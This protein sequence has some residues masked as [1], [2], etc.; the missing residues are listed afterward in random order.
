MV[1]SSA[2]LNEVASRRHLAVI[3]TWILLAF[4]TALVACPP[5]EQATP[6]RKP[7][8]ILIVLDT[9]RADHL[10]SYGYSWD[11]SP[12]LDALARDGVVF[13]RTISPSPWTIP[14]IGSIL[15]STY[16]SEHHAGERPS[17]AV[18]DVKNN[19]NWSALGKMDPTL[20][21]IASL[22][23]EHGWT[24][25]AILA[26]P[27]IRG[28]GLFP[29]TYDQVDD[30]PGDDF[31]GLSRAAKITDAAV[32]V[33]ETARDGPVFLVVHYIDPHAP[34]DPT[35]AVLDDDVQQYS[36]REMLS[37][38][39]SRAIANYDQEIRDMDNEI[40]RLLD[41]LRTK[42]HYADSLII[43]IADHGEE[44]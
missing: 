37:P 41:S 1:F 27:W 16:P 43:V 35:S 22:L 33:I 7:N 24:T 42:H 2:E 15:T 23:D 6:Q 31:A 8:I 25:H 13:E 9:V 34:Y 14:A 17:E 10:G 5:G 4:S 3:C 21:T 26:S 36:Q 30:A 29:E 18:T 11:T 38:S 44:L 32:Q 12:N 39:R 28:F 20:P 40:G 19:V